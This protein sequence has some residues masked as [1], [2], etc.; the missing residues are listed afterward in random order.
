MSLERDSLAAAIA[1]HGRVARVVVASTA[2]STPREA[3]AA[4]LVWAGGQSGTIGGGALEFEGAAQARDAL[5]AGQDRLDRIPLASALGQ[6]CGGGVTLLTEVWDAARLAK[7]GPEVFARPVPGAGMAQTD[8]AP[9]PGMPPQVQRRLAALREGSGTG[10]ALIAGWMIEPVAP[11]L[12]DLWVWGAGH[13]GRAVVG[14]VS[15]LPGW[16]ITWI[17]TE[18]GRFPDPVPPG[19]VPRIAADPEALV[20]EA[21]PGAGHLI[22]TYSHPLDL[23][24][25][26]RLL[27]HGFGSLGLIGSVTKAARFRRRLQALG[28]P[29]SEIDRI[30]C[31]IG[32]K[33]FGKHPQAIAVGV[34]ADLLSGGRQGPAAKD[35]TG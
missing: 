13:V 11:P 7:V 4:M 31:P 27:T 5:A 28:H 8:A 6:C 2:G 23:E 19:V 9:P 3:G 14:I 22:M 26:H 34:A 18:A 24:L 17:D 32:R 25:C 33:C 29:D 16:R 30:T 10:P 20:A 1:R 21:P 12:R 15:A 35:A